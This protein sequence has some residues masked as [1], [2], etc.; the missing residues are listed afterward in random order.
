MVFGGRMFGHSW[1]LILFSSLSA[2]QSSRTV[3]GEE[4]GSGMQRP[5]VYVHIHGS[6][7]GRHPWMYTSHS[8]RRGSASW[9][10]WTRSALVL[11]GRRCLL[12]RHIR[13]SAAYHHYCSSRKVVFPFL[14]GGSISAGN[15][16]DP[17]HPAP[18]LFLHPDWSCPVCGRTHLDSRCGAA[19]AARIGLLTGEIFPKGTRLPTDRR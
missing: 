18:L 6:A 2:P 19:P 9:R 5:A 16:T 3:N 1:T 10:T 7:G 17:R 12:Q 4:G 15:Q 13:S 14:L 11:M 8:T